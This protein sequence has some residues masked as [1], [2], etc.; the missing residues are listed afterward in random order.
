VGF[1]RSDRPKVT[2]QEML[3][4]VPIRNP[5][6]RIELLDDGRRIVRIPVRPRRIVRWL[7]RDDPKRPTLRSFELDELGGEVWE[8]CDGRRN[9]RRLIERFAKSHKLNLR[10]AEVSMLAYL[11]TLTSRALLFWPDPGTMRP[12]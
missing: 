6:A 10:E 4:A 5:E 11:K 12:R 3:D 9:V 8:L 1:F 7:V 2:R